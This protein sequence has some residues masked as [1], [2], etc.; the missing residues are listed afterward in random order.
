M[1][2]SSIELQPGETIIDHVQRSRMTMAP[3]ILIGGLLILLDFFFLTWLLRHDAWGKG[4]FLAALI[5]GAFILVRAIVLWKKN[6]LYITSERVIHLNRRGL[7]EKIVAE[8][9]YDKIQDVRFII[10]G[11][12]PTLTQTGTIVIQTAGS[13]EDLAVPHVFR[14]MR[15]QSIIRDQQQAHAPRPTPPAAPNRG[16][17]IDIRRS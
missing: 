4:L 5:V 6:I 8:A 15:V 1:R 7:F 11:I 12:L 9:T 17:T 16:N 13:G 14:P 10:K 3:G 2:Y